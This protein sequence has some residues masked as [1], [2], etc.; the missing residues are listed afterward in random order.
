EAVI[1]T[2]EREVMYVNAAFTRLLGHDPAD[3]LGRPFDIIQTLL[4]PGE[5]TDRL[6][7][8]IRT[9]LSRSC[10]WRGEVEALRC[11]GTTIDS[12]LTITQVP[13]VNGTKGVG[14][15]AIFRDISQEKA[16]QAQKDRFI[17]HA[18]HEMRTPLANIKTRLY[19]LRTQP[20]NLQA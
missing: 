13:G 2:R 17:A 10:S 9:S 7:D 16:L 12:A 20:D 6:R 15:V 14:Y 1:F 18:S 8:T 3:L 4:A 19:L 5:D 11:D